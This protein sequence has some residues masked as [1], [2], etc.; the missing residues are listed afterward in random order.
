MLQLFW[1]AMLGIVANESQF[2]MNKAYKGAEM[3]VVMPFDFSRL[4]FTSVLAYMFFAEIIDVWTLFGSMIIFSSSVYV[5]RREYHIR[6][7]KR[8]LHEMLEV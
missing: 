6:H 5:A 1:L 3:S 2:C 4:I 8:K 7:K